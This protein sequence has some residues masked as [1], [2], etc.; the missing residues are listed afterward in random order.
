MAAEG[1]VQINTHIDPIDWRGGGG[2]AP[3]EMVISHIVRLLQ[4]RRMGH[5]DATEPLGVLTH[6]LVH[7]A[8]IWAFSE[9][10]INRLLDGGA[11][12]LNLL[13]LKESLP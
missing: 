3:E 5:A 13:S 10:L 1:L 6:H 2:L 12:P 8:A 9:Q 4:D 11:T 7:D